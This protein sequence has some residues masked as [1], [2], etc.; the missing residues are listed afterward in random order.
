MGSLDDFTLIIPTHNRP[1]RFSCLVNLLSRYQGPIH[2]IFLDSSEDDVRSGNKDLIKHLLGHPISYS[3]HEFNGTCEPFEKFYFGVSQ[4]Q[5]NY[6][7]FCADDDLVLLECVEQIVEFL[8]THSDFVA[9]HGYYFSFQ[10]SKEGVEIQ[11]VVYSRNNLCQEERMKRVYSLFSNYEATFYA[12]YRTQA[13]KD[14]F[15]VALPLQTALW[16]EL[17]LALAS[18]MAGK[19]YRLPSFYYGRRVGDSLPFNNWHPHEIFAKK[20]DLYFTEYLKCR[21]ELFKHFHV[22]SPEEEK[23]FDLAHLLYLKEYISPQQLEAF[24][25]EN[26]GQSYSKEGVFYKTQKM[27]EALL[28]KTYKD[29]K[30]IHHKLRFMISM[31]VRKVLSPFGHK[32]LNRFTFLKPYMKKIGE[33]LVPN[34]LI[35]NVSDTP[36]A[37]SYTFGSEFFLRPLS[38]DYGSNDKDMNLIISNME[39]YGAGC[40]LR[41][42]TPST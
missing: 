21:D 6:C 19:I 18:V 35:K 39:K 40:T 42:E 34:V 38:R 26:A 3:Y 27:K 11:D 2:V 4:V 25:D 30:R 16:K 9:A 23:V 33:R 31:L 20:P 22:T 7:A 17:S 1:D 29:R 5:T 36:L 41:L 32:L 24:C 14:F 13:I 12:T 28:Q 15:T 10:F 37:F 8:K